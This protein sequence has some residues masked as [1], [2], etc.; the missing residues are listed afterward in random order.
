MSSQL[1]PDQLGPDKCLGSGAVTHIVASN[2]AAQAVHRGMHRTKPPL[3]RA[4]AVDCISIVCLGNG[5]GFDAVANLSWELR[6]SVRL[7]AGACVW[8]SRTAATCLRSS[9]TASYGMPWQ[10]ES[11]L[12]R[13]R[14]RPGGA[15]KAE[16]LA[17]G[18]GAYRYLLSNG[19]PYKNIAM[20]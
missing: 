17:E 9:V 20:I 11:S 4:G 16:G 1:G 10:M 13:T 8:A 18:A 2:D 5:G 19:I 6:S 7:L 3:F 15:D 12:Y 14:G